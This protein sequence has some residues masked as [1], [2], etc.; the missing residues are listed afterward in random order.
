MGLAAITMSM[1]A[2]LVIYNL[3]QTSAKELERG[4]R[5]QRRRMARGHPETRRGLRPGQS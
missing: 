4:R 3:D 5:L 2:L 1:L